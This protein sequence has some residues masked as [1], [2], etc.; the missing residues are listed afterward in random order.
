VTV[1][2]QTAHHYAVTTAATP[3]AGSS[4]SFSV[5][6]LD[7]FENIATGYTGKVHFSSSDA[8]AS[9]PSDA[10]TIGG[11]GT[12]AA[13]LKKAGPQ[14]IT[15]TDTLSASLTGSMTVTV[16]AAQ[17]ASLSLS[18]PATA[19]AG[20]AVAVSVT[21]RDAYENVATDYAGKVRFT[22]SD[23]SA[24]VVLPPDSTLSGGQGTFSVT[25]ARA[26]AQTIGAKDTLNASL[27]AGAAITVRAASAASLTLTAPATATPGQAFTVNVTLKDAFGNV[28][29]GYAGRV[30]FTTSDPL[31]LVVL[32]G[33][34][35]FTSAD[36][37]SHSFTVTLW[38]PGGQTLTV[39]DLAI[40][41]LSGTRSIAVALL[42]P[43][44]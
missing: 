19:T 42:P 29:T 28:A 15:A 7:A 43:L 6:A 24:G 8:T 18:A 34:Y 36:R 12:F 5:T 33:D 3:T 26:G 10:T 22:S 17:A 4:F 14:T 35:T 16:R 11:Q 30:H 20:Q 37:G 44:L 32:P 40:P 9:L 27:G 23:T 2:P 21:V 13:T 25:L 41:N 31:L 1:S 39:R 38:S